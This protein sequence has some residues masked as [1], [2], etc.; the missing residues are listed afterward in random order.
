MRKSTI[1]ITVLLTLPIISVT[2]SQAREDIYRWVDKD[3]VVHFGGQP[4]PQA[5]SELVTIEP[6]STDLATPQPESTAAGTNQAQPSYAQ[7]KR[8]ARAEKKRV[9]AQEQAQVAQQCEQARQTVAKLEP[10]P[11]VLVKQEDGSVVR[12]DDNERLE[13]LGVAKTFVAANCSN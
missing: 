1:L 6:S 2:D 9:A 7:Q 12:M 11:R 10:M 13:K 8:D 5:D 3:G 4:N